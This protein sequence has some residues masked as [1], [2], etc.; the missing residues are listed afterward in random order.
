MHTNNQTK[1]E[2]YQMT[3]ICTVTTPEFKKYIYEHILYI[4]R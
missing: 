4:Y 2:V 3:N 1:Q